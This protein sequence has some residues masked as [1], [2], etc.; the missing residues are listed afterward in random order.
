MVVSLVYVMS[1]AGSLEM[2]Y[3]DT[4]PTADLLAYKI[5]RECV[6]TR[7]VWE[8]EAVTIGPGARPPIYLGPPDQA[9]GDLGGGDTGTTGIPEERRWDRLS[10]TLT[11][12]DAGPLAVRVYDLQGRQ[13]LRRDAT[14]SGVREPFVFDL[15]AARRELA[16]G[17]YFLRVTDASGR[18]SNAVRF[19]VLK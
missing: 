19:V 17:I 13:V 5:R 15:A 6:D 16:M 8:S 14:A 12:A 10:L 3:T 1:A 4:P 9:P 2:Q 7:Y 11:G 18:A